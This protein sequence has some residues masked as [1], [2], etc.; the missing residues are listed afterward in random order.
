MDNQESDLEKTIKFLELLKSDPDKYFIEPKYIRFK[1][2]MDNQELDKYMAT[3]VMKCKVR[4]LHD[5]HYWLI[6][7]E[8]FP[9]QLKVRQLEDGT[10]FLASTYWTPTTDLNQA[11][12]CMEKWL[13]RKRSLTFNLIKRKRKGIGSLKYKAYL[14]VFPKKPVCDDD[15]EPYDVED[16]SAPLAIC[17]VIKEAINGK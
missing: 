6:L 4:E 2:S 9:Y 11:F 7:P 15:F 17:Q 10:R 1:E 5:G 12:M 16:E 8:D 14:E 13:K 3:E